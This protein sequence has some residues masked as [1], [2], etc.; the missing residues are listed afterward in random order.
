V[1]IGQDGCINPLDALA[2]GPEADIQALIHSHPAV[3]PIDEIDRAF[4]EPVPICRELNT[5]AGPLDNFLVTASGG[6][7]LVEC[8]LWRNPQA[9]REVVAQV[10]DYAKELARWNAADI[11]REVRRRTG[12]TL[13]DIV[14]ATIPHLDEPA[15]YDSLTRNLARGRCLLLIVGDGIREGVEAIFDHLRDQGALQFSFGLVELPSFQLP[16]GEKLVTPRLLARTAVE[17]RRVVELP[18][19]YAMADEDASLVLD[20]AP[21]IDERQEFWGSFLAQLRLD[22][23]EQPV[24][25]PPRMGYV[26]FYLPAPGGSCWLNAYRQMAE[27]R[28]GIFLSWNS[29]SIGERAAQAVI[30]QWSEPMKAALGGEAWLD[31]HT[32]KDGP[33]ETIFAYRNFGNLDDPAVRTVAFAWLAERTNA[34]VNVLRPAIRSAVADLRGSDR[35]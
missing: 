12:R 34:F 9:R 1:V 16:G 2:P 4:A 18:S 13:A 31:T 29:N 28:L 14:R 20:P 10:L 3:L 6:P 24:P 27:G 7:V 33:V 8:K 23:P 11:D 21:G 30:A 22:D 5:P 32:R 15:F 19:G 25:R 35:V 17:V 26:S